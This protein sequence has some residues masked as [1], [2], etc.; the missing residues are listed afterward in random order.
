MRIPK[1]QHGVLA[2]R[3][4]R[5]GFKG[6]PVQRP[7]KIVVVVRRVALAERRRRDD[8]RVVARRERFQAL[9]RGGV[10][11]DDVYYLPITGGLPLRREFLYS[12]ST[13]RNFY[14]IVP[15]L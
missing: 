3:E 8:D 11:V 1:A 2:A 9:L 15:S 4:G 6:R 10:A 14:L 12:L 13:F 5:L 7:E